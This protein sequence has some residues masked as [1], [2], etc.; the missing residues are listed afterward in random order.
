MTS[1][2]ERLVLDTN[3]LLSGMLFPDSIPSRVLRMAQS[4]IVLAS[5][6]TLLELVEVMGR[7]RFDRYVERSHRQRL[8]AE[9]INNCEMVQVAISIR[10]CRDSR[11]DKILEVAVHGRADC[12]V[13][14]DMD[15]LTLHPFRGISIL[16]PSGYLEQHFA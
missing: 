5:D 6:A 16:T 12:I 15:L 14:G 4:G 10:A 9:F 2:M 11:D 8:A 1:G 13:T 7:T 3:V